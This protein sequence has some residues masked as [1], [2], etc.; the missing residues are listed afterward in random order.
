MQGAHVSSVAL[1]RCQE[2]PH[3][4]LVEGILT[5]IGLENKTKLMQK[6][7]IEVEFTEGRIIRPSKPSC[8]KTE[9]TYNPSIWES[10][11]EGLHRDGYIE[12]CL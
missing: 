7:R 1:V 8:K 12:D 5:L 3:N 6:E 11:G 10:K 2:M 4:F 9:H